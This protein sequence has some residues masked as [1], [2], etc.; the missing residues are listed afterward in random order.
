M[1]IIDLTGQRFGSLIVVKQNGSK[2]GHKLWLCKCDC[3]KEK[4]VSGSKL[5]EGEVKSCGCQHYLACVTHGQ[6]ETRL[7]HIWCTMKARCNRPSSKKYYRYGGRGIKLCQ[8]WNDFRPFMEWA[9]S[10]GYSDN[11]SIDRIDND[12]GYN[13]QNCRWATTKEQANNR[14]TNRT[15]IIDGER[16]NMGEWGEIY[17]IK[18]S[19]IH[20]RL[21][22]GWS[23]KD[24]VT[25]PKGKYPGGKGRGHKVTIS[26]GR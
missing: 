13:P 25:I 23:E 17:G 21:S 14:S 15:I 7:Y 9:L 12:A 3:G 19:L 26:N 4:T 24:A 11:L 10:N 1:K 6:T 5:R 18:P 22:Y 8:E 2:G 20:K 16:H